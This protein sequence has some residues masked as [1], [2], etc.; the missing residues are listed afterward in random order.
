MN[1]IRKIKEAATRIRWGKVR[2]QTV[3]WQHYTVVD[4]IC[5]AEPS[6]FTSTPQYLSLIHI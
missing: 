6:A 5:F 2:R 3:D 1:P 4:H